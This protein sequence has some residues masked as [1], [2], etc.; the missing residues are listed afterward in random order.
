MLIIAHRLATVKNC[1]VIIVMDNGEIAGRERMKNCLQ[2][3]ADIMNFG[4]CSKGIL[5]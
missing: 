5:K 1:D 2:E 4:K 3:R